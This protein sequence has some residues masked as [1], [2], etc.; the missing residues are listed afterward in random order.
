[1]DRA[2][3]KNIVKKLVLLCSFLCFVNFNIHSG[4][5]SQELFLRGNLLYQSDDVKGARQSYE[6]INQ[7][8]G[9]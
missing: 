9:R 2:I 5:T 4:L 7:N 8:T 6:K 1:M 3:R